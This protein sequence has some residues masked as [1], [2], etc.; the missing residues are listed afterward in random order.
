M[1]HPAATSHFASRHCAI[2]LCFSFWSTAVLSRPPESHT[3]SSP[4]SLTARR[5]ENSPNYLDALKTIH[6]A[7]ID[8]YSFSIWYCCSS[9][10]YVQML[11]RLCKYNLHF[12]FFFINKI[13]SAVVNHYAFFE[14]RWVDI[15]LAF[16]E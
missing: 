12:M 8:R 15:I 13:T 7:I 3:G 6:A 14:V 11:N 5:R 4:V 9:W 16:W 2:V 1:D 10:A